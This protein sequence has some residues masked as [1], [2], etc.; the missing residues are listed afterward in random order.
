MSLNVPRKGDLGFL[1]FNPHSGV[2]QAGNRP[3][4]ILS[5]EAFNQKTGLA[6]V[7]PIRSKSGDWPFEV[8]LP[9]TSK[10]SG[11]VLTDQ[12]K[13]IDWKAR[14]YNYRD[15]VPESIVQECIDMIHTFIS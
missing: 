1:D 5:P 3:C 2:E 8:S 13:S 11:Y 14:N 4:L 9:S 15:T 10:I 12:V 6:V 7:C